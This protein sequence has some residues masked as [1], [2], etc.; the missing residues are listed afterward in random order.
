MD[1]VWLLAFALLLGLVFLLLSGCARLAK[2][3]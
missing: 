3:T 2:E 1:A